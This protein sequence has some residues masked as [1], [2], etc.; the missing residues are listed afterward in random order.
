MLTVEILQCLGGADVAVKAMAGE[1]SY[2]YC[3]LFVTMSRCLVVCACMHF[4]S[5]MAQDSLVQA[6]LRTTMSL[7]SKVA[8]LVYRSTYGNVFGD[9]D[10]ICAFANV[11][12]HRCCRLLLVICSDV[13]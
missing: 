3:V 8:L 13:Q 10:I 5:L 11:A 7:H 1:P 2:M 4:A 9:G 6:D 12:S